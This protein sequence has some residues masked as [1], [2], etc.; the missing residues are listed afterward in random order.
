MICDDKDNFLGFN[1]IKKGA[2]SY[3]KVADSENE[4][5]GLTLLIMKWR[6]REF[7]S[8]FNA[9]LG[10]LILLGSVSV[11]GQEYDDMYFSSSDRQTASTK[12]ELLD[13]SAPL[14]TT[15]YSAQGDYVYSEN[16][17]S[18]RTV[19]P[20]YIARYSGGETVSAQQPQSEYGSDD[21]YVAEETELVD[22]AEAYAQ[23]IYGSSSNSCHGF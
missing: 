2:L 8:I 18:A 10:A 22:P 5:L 14:A 21:Y 23:K 1:P 7:R 15:K 12:S 9:F 19:N 20:E 4:L 6:K 16:S 17:Y 13:E 3:I 11:E